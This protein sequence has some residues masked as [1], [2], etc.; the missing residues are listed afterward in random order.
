MEGTQSHND[1]RR[2]KL[3]GD[4]RKVVKTG[5]YQRRDDSHGLLS[6]IITVALRHSTLST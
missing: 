5:G 3:D 1:L 4:A 2:E 6:V